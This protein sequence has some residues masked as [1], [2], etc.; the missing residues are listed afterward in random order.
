MA[1]QANKHYH[2]YDLVVVDYTGY[3]T[4]HLPL[5]Y[6]LSGKLDSHFIGPNKVI[7]QINPVSFLSWSFLLLRIGIQFSTV[8]S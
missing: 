8:L 5:V 4:E 7:K 6:E 1:H 3:S 2:D